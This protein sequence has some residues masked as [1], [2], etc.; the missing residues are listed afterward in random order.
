MAKI[1]KRGGRAAVVSGRDVFIWDR[2]LI[3]FGVPAKPSGVRT[4]LIR[5][6]NVEERARRLVLGQYGAP[7]PENARNLAREKLAGVA[8]GRSAL[9]R[10][11]C[12]ARRH[13]GQRNVRLVSEGKRQPASFSAAVVGQSKHRR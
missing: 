13:V 10:A 9:C 6:R 7:T 5:Y 4:F 2:E 12:G 3:G 1:T 8:R 11:A